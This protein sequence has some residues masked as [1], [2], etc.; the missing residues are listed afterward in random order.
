MGAEGAWPLGREARY[1]AAARVAAP[2]D[3]AL[4]DALKGLCLADLASANV[5]STEAGTNREPS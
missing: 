3:P 1:A 2:G 4:R 5:A